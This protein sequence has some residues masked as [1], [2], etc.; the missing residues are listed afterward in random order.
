M[1]Q[2]LIVPDLAPQYYK[3][4]SL[5]LPKGSTDAYHGCFQHVALMVN[6]QA[7]LLR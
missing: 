3:L 1:G 2:L 7:Q 4:L 5:G 6:P